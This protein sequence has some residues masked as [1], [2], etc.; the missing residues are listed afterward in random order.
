MSLES[1]LKGKIVLAVDDEPD[2]L[3]ALQ[4]LLDQC[5]VVKKTNY[6]DAVEYLNSGRPDLAILDIMGVNGF[7]LLKLCVAK[8]IDT[9]M[10][11]AHAFSIESLKKSLDLG[12]RAY[13]PKEKMADIVSFLEDVVTMEHKENW[14]RSFDRLG[15]LLNAT[16]GADWSKDL[17]EIGP[18]IVPE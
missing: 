5:Q 17:I 6:K 10:L 8:K 18:F 16:F 7:D 12:A 11:T 4:E 1:P 14:Q 13:L 2:I 9:V 15:G 3:D